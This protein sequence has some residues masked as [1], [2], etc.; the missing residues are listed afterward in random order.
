MSSMI[1][2]ARSGVLA[3]RTALSVTADNVANVNTEGYVRREVMLQPL[4]G[5]AMTPTSGSSLGQ[6][7]LVQD[8]RRAFDAVASDRLRSSESSVAAMGAQ[9]SIK[10]GLEQAFL[11]TATAV[12]GAMESFFA[13][14]GSLASQPS[15]TGMR[16]VVMQE[17][18]NL[19]TSFADGAAALGALRDDVVGVAQVAVSK[20]QSLLGNLADLNRQ[21]LGVAGRMGAVNPVLDQR[22]A[23]LTQLGQEVEVNVEL[24]SI[25]RA[26]VR[27][28][29]GPGGVALLE[30]DGA[31]RLSLDSGRPLALEISQAGGT[32]QLA[33]LL[34]GRLGGQ[35]TALSAID[36]AIVD[37]NALARRLADDLNTAHRQGI[38]LMGRL[39]G[40]LFALNGVEVTPGTGNQGSTAVTLTGTTLAEPVELIFDGVAGLWRASAA[41]GEIASGRDRIDLAGLSVRLMGEARPG[42]RF[43][44]TPR[45]GQAQDMRFVLADPMALA[46]AE[47]TVASP[48]PGNKGGAV[49]T[50][51]PAATAPFAV[52]PLGPMLGAAATDA[53]SLMRAGVV[54]M[55][56]AGTTGV[57]L[58]SLGQQAG[59]DWMLPE[60]EFSAGG[61]L[62]FS[63][64]GQAHQFALPSGL[65]AAGIAEALNN[66]QILSDSGQSL[67]EL[68]VQ[69]GGAT[70]HLSLALA[71]GNFGSGAALALGAATHGAIDTPAQ[72]GAG[73]IQ[74]F[75]RSGRQIAGTPLSGAEAAS[76]L[77]QANGFLPGATYRPDWLN[78]ATGTGYLGT[79]IE[80]RLVPGAEAA[81]LTLP[82]IGRGLALP[83]TLQSGA[84]AV[85]MT[86]PEGASAAMAATMLQGAVPGLG[87]EAQTTLMLSDVA[88]GQVTLR[89][90][91]RN[92]L[93]VSLEA[94]V[95]GGDL[96]ALAQVITAQAAATGITAT[97]TP[98]GQRLMLTQGAG[99]DIRLSAIT[100]STGGTLTATAVDAT[101]GPRA[102]PVVLGAAN[103]D[104][105]VS[106]QVRLTGAEAFTLGINGS[107]LTSVSDP[108][109]GGMAT[110]QISAG[111]AV[112]DLTFAADP[113]ADA[114]GMAAD[115]LSVTAAG[116]SHHLTLAGKTVS[117]SGQSTPQDVALAL[118]DAL[119]EETPVAGLI[120][121]ALPT[122]PAE[123][124]RATILLDGARY[125]LTMQGGTVVVDGPEAGRL[126]AS[127]GSDNRLRLTVPDG[128]TDGQSLQADPADLGS[129]AFGLAPAQA[130]TV[131]LTGTPV[132]P[133][134]LPA[135]GQS[136]SIEIA[137]QRHDLT[138]RNLGGALMIDTPPGFPA[139]AMV[140]PDNAITFD[141]AL[142]QGPMRVLPGAEAAGFATLGTAVSANAAGLRLTSVD[143]SAVDSG[144]T[145]SALAAERLRLTNLPPEDLIVVMTGPGPLRLA[146]SLGPVQDINPRD[147]ELRVTDPALGLID[148]VDRTTGQSISS[149][150]LD[151]A[152]QAT[153]GGLR[154]TLSGTASA[155]D[156]FAIRTNSSPALDGRGLDRLIQLAEADPTKGRG[157]FA[158]ILSDMTGG[159]G[160]QVSAA[161]QRE[162]TLQAGHETL[163]RKVAEASAVDLDT[164][165]ARLIELQQA[166][167][168][169]AQ[170]LTIARQLFDTILNA[171]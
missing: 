142:A 162:T 137:G 120:G 53:V 50:V 118:A 77:T 106:G 144:L 148:L 14:L 19:A 119:R 1:D 55:V 139:A 18:T 43:T 42:D 85:Q 124:A 108:F 143:G 156:G 12:S 62:G 110:R 25:G 164:E 51:E 134:T 130:G 86:L 155:G 135:G 59:L 26:T 54:G 78:A 146:G 104:L 102:A 168:A 127:F 158:R 152:G 28:G 97:T 9:V 70:G 122:L 35:S 23:L 31:A 87:A 68:G 170:A 58:I 56:P 40:D 3:Y 22:D 71:D 93:P 160:A 95:V 74:V 37:L 10:E 67:T 105:R 60:A 153:L 65:G 38:D 81:V 113:V 57:D 92:S 141:L 112:Q 8:V 47:Q 45:V 154:V 132:D 128:V 72:V 133:A 150:Y 100:H 169:S 140:G 84:R 41:G 149:A 44:L 17:G 165:A 5:A 76:L 30:R 161:R 13:R 103:P 88:D 33:P 109:A 36:A 126:T 125:Q 27:L 69:A 46:A 159:I 136:L 117:V 89:L 75:T 20:V 82:D 101:A 64:A 7:V 24:D 116:L 91:G 39:G 166:Y 138:L 32:A 16:R 157:G 48:I 2:I 66:G 11:P 99:E 145:V 21:I 129:A 107:T 94:T 61:T 151:A 29:A 34:G 6:G 147:S 90:A 52:A 96:T 63:V 15:D 123:G 79:E 111:G 49:I 83:L 80:R 4:G 115:G 98:D 121:A 73:A 163:S 167:Q 171:M 131:Q 114:G